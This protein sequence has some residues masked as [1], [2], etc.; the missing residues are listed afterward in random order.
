MT[1]T[2]LDFIRLHSEWALVIVFAI[3]FI[4]SI[5]I[6]GIIL[7]GWM[8]LFGVGGMIGAGLLNFYPIVISAYFGAVFG[9]SISFYLGRHYHKN[10]LE[11]RVVAKHHKL[12]DRSRNFFLMHG[13]AGVFIA[14]FFGPTRAIVPFVAGVSEMPKRQFFWVNCLSGLLWAPLYLVPGI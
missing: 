4:E 5:L 9:E 6:I 7:P 8:L 2:L 12:I 10:I 11:W 13:V 3:A 14:R 1:D